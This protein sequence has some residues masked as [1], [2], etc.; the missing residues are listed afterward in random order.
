MGDVR[1]QGIAVLV[2]IGV[3]VGVLVGGIVA[4]LMTVT[5][6]GGVE[7]AVVFGPP[8]PAK[9]ARIRIQGISFIACRL[10]NWYAGFIE[11]MIW[12]ER[13]NARITDVS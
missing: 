2:G 13:S 3:K 4:V 7:A 10:E 9:T 11:R 5:L 8:H 6:G 1:P 12:I